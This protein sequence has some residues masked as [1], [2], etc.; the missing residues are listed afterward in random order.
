MVIITKS[1]WKVKS[2]FRGLLWKIIKK[3]SIFYSNLKPVSN[4]DEIKELFTEFH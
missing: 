3:P 4:F 2:R 1:L